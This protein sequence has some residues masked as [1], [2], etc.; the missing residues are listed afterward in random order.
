MTGLEVSRILQIV[1]ALGLLNVWLL[2]AKSAT[3][4]RGGDAKSLAEEFE[5]YGLPPW[6][7]YL[8]GILK[9][10][11][12]IALLVGIAVPMLVLPAAGL[13]VILM[14]GAVT[15]HIKVGDPPTKS[16]P[17]LAMLLMSAGIVILR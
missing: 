4:Y 7:F 10:G 6:M 16:L 11:S 1:V 17:A 12:A 15:M 3:A 8:V 9:V 2:R 14:I 5:E 13:V